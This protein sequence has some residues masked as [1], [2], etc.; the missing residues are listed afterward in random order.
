MAEYALKDYVSLITKLLQCS[1]G[2]EWA[3]FRRYSHL[4][5]AE[6]VQVLEQIAQNFIRQGDSRTASLLHHWST[7]IQ[8]QLE[9]KRIQQSEPVEQDRYDDLIQLLLD[10]P[11]GYENTILAQ[12]EALI[13][14][15][16][17]HRMGEIAQQIALRGDSSHAQYIREVAAQIDQMLSSSESSAPESVTSSVQ[18]PR[19]TA[20]VTL[21]SPEPRTTPLRSGIEINQAD[22]R[23]FSLCDKLDSLILN[24]SKVAE[25][26]AT[27]SQ[28]SPPLSYL[29]TLEKAQANKWLL[30]THEVGMI[31]GTKP[32]CSSSS[33]EYLRGGWRFVKC[34]K[35]GRDLL[36]QV[37]KIQPSQPNI[38]T[39]EFENNL[40]PSS[41]AEM[42]ETDPW[43][44]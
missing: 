17:V 15:G 6:L 39:A 22:Q 35:V 40:S 20:H 36:W 43:L 38:A 4:V 14:Q 1:E 18:P 13:D 12:H 26:I 44:A 8:K 42:V 21:T 25:A 30:S 41:T 29:D 32:H 10:C 33:T 24:L 16:L 28:H 27:Q 34:G 31:L 19:E 7:E 37:Y 9:H 2:E 23:I 5:N 11:Q 3:L